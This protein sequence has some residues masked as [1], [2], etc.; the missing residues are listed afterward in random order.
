MLEKLTN[1]CN[2]KTALIILL[3]LC[4]VLAGVVMYLLANRPKIVDICDDL[5]DKASRKNCWLKLQ[6]EGKP[7]LRIV[8]GKVYLSLVDTKK[9]K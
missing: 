7:Y 2:M 5:P 1:T 4:A 8:D 9:K 3:I 6:N